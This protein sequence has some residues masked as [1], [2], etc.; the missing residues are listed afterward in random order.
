MGDSLFVRVKLIGA[1]SFE[2]VTLIPGD[3]VSDLTR[4][5]CTELSHW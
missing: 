3:D 4:R 5:A 2:K 1:R